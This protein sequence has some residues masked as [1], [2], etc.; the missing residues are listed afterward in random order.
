MRSVGW[1]MVAARCVTAVLPSLGTATET[2]A[3]FATHLV[4]AVHPVRR[5][6]VRGH[7]QTWVAVRSETT[8]V[9]LNDLGPKIP[10][11]RP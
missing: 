5:R 9:I 10:R 6:A 3:V 8:S 1:V 2:S 7:P 4:V 11:V